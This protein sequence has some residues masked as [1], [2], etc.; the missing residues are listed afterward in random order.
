MSM[1]TDEW[2]QKR[3]AL[4]HQLRDLEAGRMSHWDEGGGGELNRNTTEESIERV[5]QR[6]ADLDAKFQDEAG[7]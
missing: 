5:K 2:R 1:D 4:I 3:E 6:L 7:S